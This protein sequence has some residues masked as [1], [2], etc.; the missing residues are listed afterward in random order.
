[1][2]HS[3]WRT[4]RKLR[5]LILILGVLS[6]VSIGAGVATRHAWSGSPPSWVQHQSEDQDEQIERVFGRF[7]GPLREG[8]AG[9]ILA[10]SGLV[11]IINMAGNVL[12]FTLP[13]ALIVPLPY[14]LLYGGWATGVGGASSPASSL[15]SLLLFQLMGLLEW[16]TYVI[17]SAAGLNIGLSVLAPRR[18]GVASRGAAFRFACGDAVRL[19]ALVALILAFAAVIEILYIRKVLLMGGTGIP[20]QPY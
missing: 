1:M 9:T 6:L 18:Q 20:L 3:I 2:L 16:V 4:V 11:F 12:N 19:Y 7:R 15:L 5:A 13:G 14:T 17:A 10:C 8:R